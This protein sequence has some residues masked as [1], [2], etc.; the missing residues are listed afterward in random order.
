MGF[1]KQFVPLAGRPMWRRSV[2]AMLDAGANHV[3]LIAS[4][5]DTVRIYRELNDIPWREDCTVVIGGQTRH[6]SV[7]NGIKQVLRDLSTRSDALES[8]CVAVHD[9]ARPFVSAEDVQAVHHLAALHG[10]AILAEPCKDT[11]KRISHTDM[12][13][14]ETLPREALWLAQTPQI[15]RGN[16]LQSVYVDMDAQG[17]TDDASL[18]EMAGLDVHVV[19][20]TSYN[21]KITTPADLELA[22]WLANRK[23]S[24]SAR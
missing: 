2:E 17:V 21:G 19:A 7:R 18:L 22:E 23:W 3:Y 20:P 11:V 10:A 4:Q 14:L 1:K 24:D 12:R 13:I 6:D 16:L 8:I 15:I 9:A 5:G